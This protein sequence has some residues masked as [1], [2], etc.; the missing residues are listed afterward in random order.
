MTNRRAN[1]RTCFVIAIILSLCGLAS[2]LHAE[3]PARRMYVGA[4]YQ[5]SDKYG[6]NP[7]LAGNV[8][9]IVEAPALARVPPRQSIIPSSD[10][11]YLA[12]RDRTVAIWVQGFTPEEVD[13]QAALVSASVPVLGYVDSGDWTRCPERVG[14]VG[15][16]AYRKRG[17]SLSAFDTRIRGLVSLCGVR[18]I[19]LVVQTYD[20]NL[21]LDDNV[22]EQFQY[23][24]WWSVSIPSVVAV[25]AFSDGRALA[26][27]SRGGMRVHPQWTAQF[28][29]V[30]GLLTG[31][32]RPAPPTGLVVVHK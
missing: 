4:F 22:G 12:P 7:T 15:V 5:W 25:L 1:A 23:Y 2:I 30:V 17:E 24:Y 32:R 21:S 6:D 27:N 18:P 19:A 28:E 20:T 14:W 31:I 8:S 10:I 3:A 11:A 26:D 9:V 16:Q 29:A 13:A